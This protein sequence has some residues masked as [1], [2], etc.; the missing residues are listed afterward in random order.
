MTTALMHIPVCYPLWRKGLCKRCGKPLT[1]RRQKYCSDEC[2]D[3]YCGNH[4]WNMA[5]WECVHRNGYDGRRRY[6][7]RCDKCGRSIDAYGFNG[8][9]HGWDAAE[10]D[11][12]IP[13]EGGER[14]ETCLNHQYLLR[15]LCH[16]C[17]TKRHTSYKEPKVE[18]PEIWPAGAMLF[19]RDNYIRTKVTA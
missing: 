6:Q 10:V 11:H 9:G 14:N 15:C 17:H 2:R 19:D 12:L 7:T 4:F 8:Y 5:R 13:L 3:I 1:G 16:K 18:E